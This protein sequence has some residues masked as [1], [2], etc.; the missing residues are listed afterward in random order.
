MRIWRGIVLI[1]CVLVLAANSWHHALFPQPTWDDSVYLR[2]SFIFYDALQDG[3]GHFL[4][5][6]INAK[7][8]TSPPLISV[9]PLPLYFLF[10]PSERIA[11]WLNDFFLIIGWMGIYKIGTKLYDEYAGL[12]VVVATAL[13][14]LFYGL[15]RSYLIETAFVTIVIVSQWLLLGFSPQKK[16]HGVL[17]GLLAGLGLLTKTVYPLFIIGTVF[18]LRKKLQEQFFILLIVAC[19]VASIWYAFH[20]EEEF[21]TLVSASWGKAALRSGSP[22]I[23]SS[24]VILSYLK[25]LGEIAFSW[26]Y[27]GVACGS[28][29]W[30]LKLRQKGTRLDWSE[31]FLILW[32]AVPFGVCLFVVNNQPRYLAAALPAMT[33]AVGIAVS[34]ILARQVTFFRRFVLGAFILIGP[35]FV[36]VSQ[37]FGLPSAIASIAYNGPPRRLGVWNREDV[38]RIISKD[39]GGRPV[40]VGVNFDY[41][42]FSYINLYCLAA[43]RRYSIDFLTLARRP[44]R[45]GDQQI[46]DNFGLDYLIIIRGKLPDR[47]EPLDELANSYRSTLEQQ[48]DSGQI[49][50]IKIVDVSQVDEVMASIYRLLPRKTN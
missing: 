8:M 26:P 11:L 39:S 30:A 36:F 19:G 33:L 18:L 13:L 31:K 10:G 49:P 32:F 20:W 42:A 24:S 37:T 35:L 17:L 9:F 47:I 15:S 21:K 25:S 43:L 50:A 41:P 34:K 16:L 23:F 45:L 38:L 3:L 44:F 2:I 29:T 22:D 7:A 48:I 27:A 4:R 14:P 12:C 28:L 1:F 40:F 6:F 5:E 46:L